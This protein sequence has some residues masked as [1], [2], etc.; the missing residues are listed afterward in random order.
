MQYAQLLGERARRICGARGKAKSSRRAG[1]PAHHASRRKC[2]AGRQQP[3]QQREANGGRAQD[4]RQLLGIMGIRSYWGSKGRAGVNGNFRN[5]S[6][7]L[8]CTIR[9][10][11]V[12]EQVHCLLGWE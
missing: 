5:R 7:S 9:E 10:T 3:F 8:G 4:R 11:V 2:D 6:N 1:S 12:L